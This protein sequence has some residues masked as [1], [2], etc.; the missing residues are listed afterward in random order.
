M[1]QPADITTRLAMAADAQVISSLL[2]A[3][4]AAAGGT[5]YGDW[6]LPVVSAWIARG[7]AIVLAVN[8]PHLAGVLFTD[9]PAAATAPPVLAA[10]EVWPAK[11]GAYVY[12]PVCVAEAYRGQGI[13]ER[14]LQRLSVTL[15]GKEGVLFINRDNERS[16]R[17][18]ERLGMHEQASFELNGAVYAVLTFQG[19]A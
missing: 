5:L 15:E 8:G 9:D 16:L 11:P 12:G 2:L 4:A 7:V 14:L 1:D 6:S 17:A 18:H 19:L 13:F 10:L 3:N